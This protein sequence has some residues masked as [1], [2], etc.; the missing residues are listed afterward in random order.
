MV[1]SIVGG[2]KDSVLIGSAFGSDF[3]LAKT[4]DITSEK[5]IEEDNY[6]AALE[7]MENYGVDITS[8]SLG[9]STFD[10][11]EFSY[12][13]SDMDGQTTIVTRAAELAFRRGVLTMTSAGNE[14]GAL[15]LSLIHI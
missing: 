9:Y 3:I 6:A 2:F 5:H 15:W 1:F 14:G 11:P 12:T 4:E 7:W 10:P 13:Y 8:S